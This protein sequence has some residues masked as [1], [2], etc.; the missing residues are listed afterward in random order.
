M[1]ENIFQTGYD[2]CEISFDVVKT[3][4]A[5]HVKKKDIK[6]TFEKEKT[7]EILADA[8]SL[9]HKLFDSTKIEGFFARGFYCGK[10]IKSGSRFAINYNILNDGNLALIVFSESES[11]VSTLLS[12][13][14]LLMTAQKASEEKDTTTNIS[15]ENAV[16]EE[17]VKTD[18]KKTEEQAEPEE[19]KPEKSLDTTSEEKK[20]GETLLDKPSS[21]ID[22]KEKTKDDTEEK[23]DTNSLRNLIPSASSS[24]EQK[25]EVKEDSTQNLPKEEAAPDSLE[26]R[27]AK[28]SGD[29]G[30]PSEEEIKEEEPKKEEDATTTK[31]ED[32]SDFASII[33][34]IRSGS[35]ETI[36]SNEEQINPLEK[37]N[38]GEETSVTPDKTEEEIEKEVEAVDEEPKSIS[39]SVAS[40]FSTP[41]P[42]EKKDRSE[43]MVAIKQSLLAKISEIKCAQTLDLINSVFT[44]DIVER[45]YKLIAA[46]LEELE[47]DGK[48]SIDIDGDFIRIIV[49]VHGVGKIED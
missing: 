41:P 9:L 44:K 25:E 49:P 8:F 42:V 18:V 12:Q 15:S 47:V 7:H 1:G 19:E 27:L 17:R 14:E 33:G 36:I 29:S 5:K 32:T 24:S 11:L 2:R 16:V 22:Q 3:E 48:V 38:N 46:A 40:S 4:I 13:I 45:D 10:E 21:N 30:V 31:S 43:D 6:T 34:N 23:E 37:E 35:K 28:L 26:S 39:E 20:D